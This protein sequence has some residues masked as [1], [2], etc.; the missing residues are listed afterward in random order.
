MV[1]RGG[2]ENRCT[3]RYRG[4]ESLLLCIQTAKQLLGC[5]Y[6]NQIEVSLLKEPTLKKVEQ[7]LNQTKLH[8][9][10]FTTDWVLSRKELLAF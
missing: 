1:D 5:F 8:T 3:E 6:F 7:F 2:L 10:D 9:A 4:F